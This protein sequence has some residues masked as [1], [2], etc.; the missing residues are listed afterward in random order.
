MLESKWLRRNI[1]NDN[2]RRMGGEWE[3]NWIC[4]MC[5][6]V[7]LFLR[8]VSLGVLGLSIY[9]VAKVAKVTTA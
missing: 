6:C 9:K 5:L 4:Y 7:L 1:Y 8:M 3:D 2:G